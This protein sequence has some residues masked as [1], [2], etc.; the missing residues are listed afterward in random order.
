MSTVSRG[1]LFCK[2]TLLENKYISIPPKRILSYE[3]NSFSTSIY[4][5]LIMRSLIGGGRGEGG[6]KMTAATFPRGGGGKGFFFPSLRTSNLG[7][8][9]VFKSIMTKDLL[10]RHKLCLTCFHIQA[11]SLVIINSSARSACHFICLCGIVG[12]GFVLTPLP[13][14]RNVHECTYSIGCKRCSHC[15]HPSRYGAYPTT[16]RP[17]EQRQ[18]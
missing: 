4:G 8:G 9:V 11:F 6:A 15:S 16:R 3:A 13:S 5:T 2:D 12:G 18:H 10:R 1:N 14:Y 17:G 7:G